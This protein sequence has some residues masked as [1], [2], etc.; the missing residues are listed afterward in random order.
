VSLLRRLAVA[1]VALLLLQLTLLGSG[2]LCALHE[3]AVGPSASRHGMASMPDVTGRD[4]AS[5]MAAVQPDG[6]G[7][8]TAP[9]GCDAEGGPHDCGLP[10]SS[11]SCA[12]MTT[13][14]TIAASPSMT[15]AAT[16]RA[17]HVAELPEPAQLRTG[18]AAAPELPPPRA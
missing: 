7:S 18:P 3:T 9:S 11:G 12:A 4:V 2:T 16:Q 1:L 10:W 15:V 6:G 8:S 17:A 14:A 5:S 13:C